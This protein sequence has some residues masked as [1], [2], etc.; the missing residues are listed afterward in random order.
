VP[1]YYDLDGLIGFV[2]EKAGAA[3]IKCDQRLPGVVAEKN[4]PLI[5]ALLRGI[6]Q[7]GGRPTFKK[8]T[9][10]S[11]MCILGPAWKCPIAAYG[12]GDSTLDHTPDE[13]IVLDEY[14][15]SIEVLTTAL[16]QLTAAAK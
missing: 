11:D 2:M 14:L 13:H 6:R 15:R 3:E 7:V 9:G 1:P 5:R 8:K 10:T 12:P 4:T 16:E